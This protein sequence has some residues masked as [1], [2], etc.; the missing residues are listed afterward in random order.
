MRIFMYITQFMSIIP[1]LD[2]H[3]VIIQV[4][5]EGSCVYTTKIKTLHDKTISVNKCMTVGIIE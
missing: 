4:Y 3:N 5:L 2:G 1:F